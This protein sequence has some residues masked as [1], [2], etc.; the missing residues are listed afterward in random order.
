MDKRSPTERRNSS[1][2]H[3]LHCVILE[4]RAATEELKESTRELEATL[5]EFMAVCAELRTAAASV[6]LQDLPE[7]VTEPPRPQ[8]PGPQDLS[9]AQLKRQADL[10]LKKGQHAIRES[11][12]LRLRSSRVRAALQCV[13]RPGA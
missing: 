3:F 1:A 2:C 10:V 13:E 7:T 8:E 11:M 12:L 4:Q 5:D 9:I 6:A